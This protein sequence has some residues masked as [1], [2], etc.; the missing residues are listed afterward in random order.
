MPLSVAVCIPNTGTIK[1][2]TMLSVI[3]TIRRAASQK[4]FIHV[5]GREGC[6]V[7][8]NRYELVKHAMQAKCDKVLFVDADM[9]FDGDVL[10]Q[11][12]AHRKPI[13]GV[14]YYTRGFPLVSTVKMPGTKGP[15]GETRGMNEI[16]TEPFECFAVGTGLMLID[17]GVFR[18][19]PQPWFQVTHLPDGSLGWG[20]D[21]WFCRQARQ[22]GFSVWC[23]PTIDV[24]HLGD[25]RYKDYERFEE[26]GGGVDTPGEQ[27]AVAVP[28][29]V[30]V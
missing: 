18:K 20:E 2:N 4:I 17:M 30:N 26:A 25:F 19:L 5:F 24:S 6:Y 16:P 27:P 14:N 12:L 22:H 28:E 7:Q 11:L 9:Q 3:D 10:L 23:D 8:L 15:M 1:M 29:L 21:V 13:V